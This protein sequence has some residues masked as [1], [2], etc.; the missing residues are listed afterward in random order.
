M[1]KIQSKKESGTSKITVINPMKP[2]DS[3]KAPF[4]QKVADQINKKRF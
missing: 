4:A 1:V 2:L 3:P